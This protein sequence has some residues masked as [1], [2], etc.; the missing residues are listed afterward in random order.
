MLTARVVR[1]LRPIAAT[2]W[3][4][5]KWGLTAEVREI[6]DSGEIPR[7]WNNVPREWRTRT[8]KFR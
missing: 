7:E 6:T 2:R 5:R 8:E 3:E 4:M 1:K